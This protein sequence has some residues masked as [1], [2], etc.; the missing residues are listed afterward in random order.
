MLGQNPYAGA[1]TGLTSKV[2]LPHV[3]GGINTIPI[4]NSLLA[5][6]HLNA[7]GMKVDPGVYTNRFLQGL[8]IMSRQAGYGAGSA[9]A[10]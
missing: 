10:L 6:R 4:K 9:G 2:L 3:V 5:A 7:T 1:A 8:G